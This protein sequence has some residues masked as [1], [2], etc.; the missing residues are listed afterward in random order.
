MQIIKIEDRDKSIMLEEIK[1][2]KQEN[3]RLREQNIEC[4]ALMNDYRQME[5]ALD[6]SEKKFRSILD[7]TSEGIFII[8]D[9][10]CLYANPAI[11]RI[12]GYSLPELENF[13]II[14]MI[15]EEDKEIIKKNYAKRI[16]GKD[17]PLYNVRV[18]R[19]DGKILFGS[20]NAS[21]IKW[22]NEEALLYLIRDNTEGIVAEQKL[23]RNL[24][25]KNTLLKE[26]FHRTKNNMQVIIS[27]I[28][29]KSRHLNNPKL[30]TIFN[31]L[32]SKIRIMS[33]AHQELY[34]SQNLSY[35]KLNEYI[36]EI[37]EL[38]KLT[39]MKESEKID[40]IHDLEKISVSIDKA[41]PL[42]LV[43]NE[44]ISNSIKHAFP[45]DTMGEIRI[46][47]YQDS[48]DH[49]NLEFNDNGS[50]IKNDINLR[51]VNSL[52]L[53]NVFSMILHQLKG[54]ISYENLNGLHWKIRFKDEV[55]NKRMFI[56]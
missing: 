22:K 13:T 5:I 53:Q 6:E 34:L 38:M 37:V 3:Q 52:G 25:E 31:E 1:I 18:R 48:Q 40:I 51:E 27:M 10:K 49:I 20:I 39:N 46:K 42:G 4:R 24:K 11:E 45:K 54:E 29:I 16:T 35:L 15:I 21:L 32:N 56:A 36:E 30:K 12:S 55:C 50:G 7:N 23:A 17:I 9:L 33:L 2:L 41:L 14:D 47:L 8:K 26:L 19:K 43:I 28:S 44:L